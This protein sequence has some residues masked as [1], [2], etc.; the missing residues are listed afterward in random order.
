MRGLSGD[1]S[2]IK[3]KWAPEQAQHEKN[4]FRITA[5]ISAIDRSDKSR[6][7]A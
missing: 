3:K 7:A 1:I 2:A 4:S 6:Q 5:M